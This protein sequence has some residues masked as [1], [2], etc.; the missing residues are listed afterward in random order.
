VNDPGRTI[1]FGECS[2]RYIVLVHC[3]AGLQLLMQRG[4]L[5][6][7]QPH[8]QRAIC[9][10]GGGRRSLDSGDGGRVPITQAE[11]LERA[12]KL[13]NDKARELGWIV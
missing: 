9:R 13:A 10:V 6:R 1:D 5:I 12:W 11:F 8:P 7:S 3:N 2:M 4:A